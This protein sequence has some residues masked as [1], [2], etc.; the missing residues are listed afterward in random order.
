MNELSPDG[1]WRWDGSQWQPVHQAPSRSPVQ[2][3][4]P[5]SPTTYAGNSPIGG[6]GAQPSARTQTWQWV[7]AIVALAVSV[8][9]I[10]INVII[11]FEWRSDFSDLSNYPS[12]PW[13]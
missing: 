10:L 11:F 9:L 6:Y 4:V 8:M 3:P 12:N 7:I 5:S 2:A 13:Y 1:Q